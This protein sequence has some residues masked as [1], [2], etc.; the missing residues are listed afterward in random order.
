MPFFIRQMRLGQ[1][2]IYWNTFCIRW[3]HRGNHR[4]KVFHALNLLKNT[5]PGVTALITS[6]DLHTKASLMH[7]SLNFHL[8]SEVERAQVSNW[9]N[10]KLE[11]IA[12]KSLTD[13]SIIWNFLGIFRGRNHYRRRA[14]SSFTWFQELK[15][16]SGLLAGTIAVSPRFR[17]S[18]FTSQRTILDN[19]CPELV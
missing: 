7:S 16:R 5:L 18:L 3:R 11:M 14:P 8:S 10:L 15:R 2:L 4:H 12:F 19:L 9:N 1:G 6:S 13:L 17:G